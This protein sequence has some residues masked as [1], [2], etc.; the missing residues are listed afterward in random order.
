MFH[1]LFFS[2]FLSFHSFMAVLLNVCSKGWFS[3]QNVSLLFFSHLLCYWLTGET[4]FSLN[5]S[6]ETL[7]LAVSHGSFLVIHREVL[8]MKDE[9]ED[10]ATLPALVSKPLTSFGFLEMDADLLHQVW[11]RPTQLM[12]GVPRKVSQ[13]WPVQ[14]HLPHHFSWSRYILALALLFLSWAW[15][16]IDA[17]KNGEL[18]EDTWFTDVV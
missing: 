1:I 6:Q 12:P 11:W 3:S 17:K 10:A 8:F 16:N 7:S 13:W 9:E 4:R 18:T 2:C 15:Q 14:K 5:V